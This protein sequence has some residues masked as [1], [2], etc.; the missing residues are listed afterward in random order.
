MGAASLGWR[1]WKSQ[2][3]AVLRQC[4]ET[5]GLP[6]ARRGTGR[7]TEI[8]HWW[9]PLKKLHAWMRTHARLIDLRKVDRVWFFDFAFGG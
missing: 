5:E 8:D 7:K 2:E 3:E 9:I 6:A 4:Y 1:P